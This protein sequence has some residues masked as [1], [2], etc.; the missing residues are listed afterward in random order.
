IYLQLADVRRG[1][2]LRGIERAHAALR[3]AIGV[4]P[5]TRISVPEQA[6]PSPMATVNREEILALALARRAELVQVVMASQV[7]ELEVEAQGKTFWPKAATFASAADIHAHPVP[8]GI[9]NREYRP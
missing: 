6:L 8:Q 4:P 5:E 3:E 2:A 7:T 1:E 9:S